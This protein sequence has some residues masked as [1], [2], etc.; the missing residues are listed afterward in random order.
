MTSL[1][2]HDEPWREWRSAIRRKSHISLILMDIDCFKPYND[3]YGHLQGDECLRTVGRS[4]VGGAR[5]P[6][7]LVARY[8][9]EEFACVLPDTGLDRRPASERAALNERFPMNTSIRRYAARWAAA[10]LAFACA[11]CLC[12]P[13]LAAE[14]VTRSIGGV[15]FTV[16]AD[17]HAMMVRVRRTASL[18]IDNQLGGELWLADLGIASTTIAIAPLEEMDQ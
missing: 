3:F 11:L 16:P 2:G 7:E 5:R 10:M 1:V 4:L 12:L 9:G 17:C 14:G 15:N 18:Q 13:A 6:S 8:G